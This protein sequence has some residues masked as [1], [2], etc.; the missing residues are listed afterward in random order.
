M[1]LI[2]DDM[3]RDIEDHSLI[4]QHAWYSFIGE[5]WRKIFA[6]ADQIRLERRAPSTQLDYFGE[7]LAIKSRCL[8]FEEFNALAEMIWI[9]RG[10]SILFPPRTTCSILS[11]REPGASFLVCRLPLGAEE[12]GPSLRDTRRIILDTSREI[13]YVSEVSLSDLT[14]EIEQVTVQ[15]T[16][17]A[18][19]RTL[20]KL[21]LQALW[22]YVGFIH[23][24]LFFSS[25]C[26]VFRAFESRDVA[27]RWL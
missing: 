14:N 27:E 4:K 25:S 12:S 5:R 15:D 26:S 22:G 23:A 6:N 9:I 18:F 24:S 11:Q 21:E 7:I 13:I 17:T 20:L 19:N 1:A 10:C 16:C 3:Q 8:I 2:K